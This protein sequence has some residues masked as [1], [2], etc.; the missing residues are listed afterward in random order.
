MITDETV[1]ILGAGTSAPYGFPLASGLRD[2]IC[3]NLAR[4]MGSLRER[5][6]GDYGEL[7]EPMR[8]IGEFVG[9]FQ[10]SR[11]KSIDRWLGLNGDYRDIGKLAIVNVI[12]KREAFPELSTLVRIMGKSLLLTFDTNPS[13]S[14]ATTCRVRPWLARLTRI[15]S[16][17]SFKSG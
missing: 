16:A 9:R 12:V 3:L 2:D 13:L 1:F 15:L 5:C 11:I 6:K 14:R 4:D 7:F 17:T 8:K 10:D